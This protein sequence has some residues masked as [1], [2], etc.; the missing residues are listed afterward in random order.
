M[1]TKSTSWDGYEANFI[2]AV[3]E[4]RAEGISAGVFGDID[5]EGHREWVTR[6]CSTVEIEPVI[7]LWQEERRELLNEFI[8]LG[9]RA[10]IVSVKDAALDHS[11]LGR[12]LDDETVEELEK[13]GVDICGEEGEYHTFVT[14]GP[15]FSRPVLFDTIGIKNHDGYSFLEISARDG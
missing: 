3:R 7:P 14:D 11:F 12:Y 8:S 2:D 9:F 6:V 15:E 10:L 1:V 5:L 4:L 13:V